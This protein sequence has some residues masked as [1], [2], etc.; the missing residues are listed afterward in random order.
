[1]HIVEEMNQ[2]GHAIEK[3]RLCG[4]ILK[5]ERWLREMADATGLPIELPSEPE[6]VLLGSAMLAAT[7][8]GDQPDLRRA[9]ATM[10]KT[11]RT[12]APRPERR[13]F[14]EAKY[15]VYRQMHADQLNYRK[16]MA[17]AGAKG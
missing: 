2:H 13:T 8:C 1:R 16:I 17:E 3:L 4:G 10:S 7:A 5:N 14:H 6:A 12:I 9:A 15:R 11:D